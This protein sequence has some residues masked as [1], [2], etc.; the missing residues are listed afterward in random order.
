MNTT[1]DPSAIATEPEW[2]NDSMLSPV[3]VTDDDD[4]LLDEELSPEDIA[5][6]ARIEA[7]WQAQELAR[8]DRSLASDRREFRDDLRARGIDIVDAMHDMGLPLHSAEAD[9]IAAMAGYHQT[10]WSDQRNVTRRAK[11]ATKRVNSSAATDRAK[12]VIATQEF[13]AENNAPNIPQSGDNIPETTPNIPT[14][15]VN[16]PAEVDAA[17]LAAVLPQILE[18]AAKGCSYSKR[19]VFYEMAAAKLHNRKPAYWIHQLSDTA[20]KD[21]EVRLAVAWSEAKEAAQRQIEVKQRSVERVEDARRRLSA[22]M[23]QVCA[24]YIE[25]RRRPENQHE[26][27][28]RA[29]QVSWD[30]LCTLAEKQIVEAAAKPLPDDLRGWIKAQCKA[31]DG[32]VS[33]ARELL[34]RKAV[35]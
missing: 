25:L 32:A 31:A 34:E 19:S 10:T 5:E 4:I 15:A 9:R 1:L 23:E 17:A 18:R 16:I 2:C 21:C 22:A 12:S 13:K 6:L 27:I 3:I 35:Q 29:L 26:R 33:M 20:R 24:H 28:K 7:E 30:R 8:I 11:E 14:Q